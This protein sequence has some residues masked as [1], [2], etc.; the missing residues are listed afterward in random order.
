MI[1][2]S[3]AQRWSADQW[4]ESFADL[5]DNPKGWLATA[6]GAAMYEQ[7][8]TFVAKPLSAYAKK[9]G[10]PMTNEEVTHTVLARLASLPQ[11]AE[12]GIVSDNPAGYL[13]RSATHWI[14]AEFCLRAGSLEKVSLVIAAPEKIEYEGTVMDVAIDLTLEVLTPLCAPVYHHALR[15]AVTLFAYNPT[16]RLSYTDKELRYVHSEVAEMTLSQVRAVMNVV[17]GGRPNNAETSI[18]GQFLRN[19]EWRPEDSPTHKR[20]L[21]LFQAR[22]FADT[23]Q[24]FHGDFTLAAS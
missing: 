2:V 19:P 23:P 15:R 20:A 24:K 9:N 14:E 16:T 17:W 7:V 11:L 10:Y 6:S 21:L 4:R 8:A 18:T 3:E 12:G 13:F 5:L 22:M 1:F